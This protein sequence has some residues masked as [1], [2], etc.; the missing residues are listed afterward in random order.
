M[1]ALLTERIATALAQ[2]ASGTRLYAL[3][4]GDRPD[5]SDSVEFLVEAFAAD[6][7][8]Q[9]IGGRDVIVVSTDAHI[10]LVPLLGQP[11]SLE[12][13]LA[14]GT[15]TSFAGDISEVAMLGSEGGL[16]RYRLRL[17]PWMWRLSQVRNSRVWQ[18]KTVIEIVEDVF[19]PYGAVVKWRWSDETGPF[20]AIGIQT[21][22]GRVE[23]L[24]PKRLERF[25]VDAFFHRAVRAGG[26]PV[27]AVAAWA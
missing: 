14:D 20:M 8:V 5:G 21:A 4:V 3:R 23:Q 13:S 6:D 19:A 9:G 24:H 26:R 2:F 7:A 12:V 15:R 11:A 10:A 18:D 16:A 25:G 1:S 22:T 27:A 17:S